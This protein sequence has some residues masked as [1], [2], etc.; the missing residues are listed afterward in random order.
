MC[1]CS[2]AGSGTE[3]RKMATIVILATFKQWFVNERESQLIIS[4]GEAWFADA[5]VPL[6]LLHAS[7]VT[8]DI[9]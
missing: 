9:N 8:G 4:T 5:N 7:P 2:L 6:S 3:L 1:G